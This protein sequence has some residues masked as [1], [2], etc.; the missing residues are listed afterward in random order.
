MRYI[1]F[2]LVFI[3]FGCTAQNINQLKP[4]TAAGSIPM[5]VA[6]YFRQAYVRPQ[7]LADTLAP[8]LISASADSLGRNG[9]AG[10]IVFETATRAPNST[11]N[12]FYDA[13]NIRLGLGTSSPNYK[14]DVRSTNTIAAMQLT[15]STSGYGASDGL[16]TQSFG[17]NATLYNYESGYLL[18][19]T[20]NTP[21][22][23]LYGT[24]QVRFDHYDNSTSFAATPIGMLGYSPSGL[25]SGVDA[26]AL[27]SFLSV[28]GSE[29]KVT[30]GTNISVTGSGTTGSPYVITNTLTAPDGSETVVTSGT[31][32][33]VSGSGTA[34][35]PYVIGNTAVPDGSETKVTAGT[36]VTV[37]GTG[38]ISD[39]YVINSTGSADK[40]G[41]A[42]TS[43][44]LLL[45]DGT[46]TGKTDAS[47]LF[48]D[49]GNNR[50]GIGLN[51][52][53]SGISY[54]TKLHLY[55]T[56]SSITGRTA[57][58]VE[59]GTSN[60][61][62]RFELRNNAGELLGFQASGAG[63][64][65]GALGTV[66]TSNL[67]L[68][69]LTNGSV[70][71]G[72]TND[73]Y[74]APGGY[75]HNTVIFDADG[76]V[77]IGTVSPSQLLHV[78]GT[79]RVTGSTGTATTIMGRNASGDV[80]NVSTGS[81]LSLSSGTLSIATGG[82]GSTEIVS[83]GV[84]AAS[85]TNANITVDADGRITTASNGS[86]G[87][88]KLGT[89]FTSGQ[90]IYGDGS[91]TGQANASF[92]AS[93]STSDG[94]TITSQDGTSGHSY[95]NLANSGDAAD[96]WRLY[97]SFTG[98]F[99]LGYSSA[100][101]YSETS[102][103][104]VVEAGS[105]TNSI[106]IDNSGVGIG[107]ITSPTA[108]LDV[109]GIIKTS[110]ISISG[111]G[112][113][114]TSTADLSLTTT[115]SSTGALHL[116]SNGTTEI[117]D[118]AKIG[119]TSGDQLEILTTSVLAR[120]GHDE[121]IGTSRLTFFDASQDED[122]TLETDGTLWLEGNSNIIMYTGSTANNVIVTGNISID[123]GEVSDGRSNLTIHNGTPPS[124]SVANGV[125]LYAD[126][127]SSS[128]ELRVRDESGAT[129]TLSPHN[130]SKIPDGPSEDMAWSFYSE[131]EGQYINVDMLKLARLVEEI[132]GEKLVYTGKISDNEK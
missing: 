74:F 129:T 6:P 29:T 125:I 62:A 83:T 98:N 19:A 95:L 119:A 23:T 60:S 3:T 107:G 96:T 50:L 51:T 69:I 33:S 15:N 44:A 122:I 22:V 123:D 113:Y 110:P 131:K 49:D 1:V 5:T 16:L 102:V 37:T 92:T 101:S 45:G 118:D 73:I 18:L 106:R 87:A 105:T 72:G 2:I 90:M 32:I 41:T 112:G 70:T 67:D 124:T 38:L 97:R 81:S 66:G 43:G 103:P 65:T 63:Y 111:S 94:M 91:T 121:A 56:G 14:I 61:A 126:D 115:S 59:N 71:T 27:L 57:F 24:G 8:Y 80:S 39:P 35:S 99:G 34:G 100:L 76:S 108:A 68:Q 82:V 88:D 20:N 36:N 11:P 116:G 10:Q 132:T 117:S 12:L 42:F 114:I 46:T 64:T 47:N 109:N 48:W 25:V 104:F 75:N 54:D 21:V 89:A 40:L 13:S 17:T 77:G 128:S 85:Y 127:V 28:D 130:F 26:A 7:T 52:P 31:G 4:D 58:V 53:G 84:T 86:S 9:T 93:A 78:E 55:G 120:I 79:A 30:A